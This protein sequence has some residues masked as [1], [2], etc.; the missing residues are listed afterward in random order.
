[1]FFATFQVQRIRRLKNLGS[2]KTSGF[3]VYRQT[4][5]GVVS[6]LPFLK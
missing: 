5:Y 2:S 4:S 3:T 6:L 1:M